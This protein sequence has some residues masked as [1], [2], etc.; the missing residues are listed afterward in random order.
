M[1]GNPMVFFYLAKGWDFFFA[2]FDAKGHREIKELRVK[3]L[4]PATA[5]RQGGACGAPSGQIIHNY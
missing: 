4:A 5:G 3:L 2:E 1:A